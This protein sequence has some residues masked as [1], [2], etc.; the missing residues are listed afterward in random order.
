[1]KKL[2]ILTLAL[3]LFCFS[4]PEIN[5]QEQ[6]TQQPSAEELEKEKADRATKAYRLLDQVID[7][8]QSLRL[9]EN[10][11]RV[12]I[13]AADIL[14][15]ENQGR[16]RSLFAMAAD[17]VAELS[18]YQS[19]IPNRGGATNDGMGFTFQGGIGPRNTRNLVQ[20]RQ[21]LILTVARHDATL[22]YQLLAATKPPVPPQNDQRGPRNLSSEE[23]LEQAL[24]A[25]ISSLDPKLAAQNAEQMIDK[26][27]FPRT[28]PEV[29]NQLQRQ[30]P[31]AAA[32]LADKTVKKIQATNI[33]TNNEANSLAQMLI[34][35]GPR[36]QVSTTQTNA[37]IPSRGPVLDQSLFVDLLSTMVDAALKVTP[38]PTNQRTAANQRRV[39]TVGPGGNRSGVGA[40]PTEAQSEQ[41]NGRIL[42]GNLQMKMALIEQYLP[43]KASLV[44][45]K[46]AE[47][48]LPTNQT[49][50]DFP[51]LRNNPTA[52]AL[53]QAAA[54][55]PQQMQSRL[56]QQA[57]FK[58]LEEG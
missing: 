8:A 42:L 12:Q 7:E 11:V 23:N 29:L 31:E 28:L 38:S 30:D 39:V 32:K 24:L 21:D 33:L 36:Q 56:Y 9:T 57:A 20:L 6:P 34:A 15:D 37:P 14:W 4:Q 47:A 2:L 41:L 35:Y 53:Y 43:A 44:R 16:A 50:L 19:P 40:P 46:A 51:A 27:Q 48:G 3:G 1:M 26:G 17:G 45:Q 13:I 55:A 25:R 10:R 52:D 54:S 5:A 49:T 22:A 18:R 58:A